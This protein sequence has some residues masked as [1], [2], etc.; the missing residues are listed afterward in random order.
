MIVALIVLTAPAS[1][2]WIQSCRMSMYHINF[3]VQHCMGLIAQKGSRNHYM[4]AH[5]WYSGSAY[6]PASVLQ[7]RS[8]TPGLPIGRHRR[9]EWQGPQQTPHVPDADLPNLM[10][11]C[12]CRRDLPPLAFPSEG[13]AAMNGRAPSKRH[14]YQT[15]DEINQILDQA[16]RRGL[17]SSSP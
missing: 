12:C 9:N 8:A 5:G 10:A 6:D 2:S 16:E 3:F 1:A 13:S 4:Q 11:N 17:P 7:E 15:T 14:A